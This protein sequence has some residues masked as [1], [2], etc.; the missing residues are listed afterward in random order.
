MNKL[1]DEALLEV[2]EL[3]KH[4]PM[5]KK[6]RQ[7]LPTVVKAVD[8]VS[9]SIKKGKTLGI[10]GE[11]GSGKS[12]VANLILQLEEPTEGAVFFH[13]ENLF[14]LSKG[15]NRDMRKHLQAIFQ[16]PYA[17]LNPRMTAKH[18]VTEPLT[19]HKQLLNKNIN[20]KA[21]ELLKEVGLGKEHLNRYPH[22]F[23]G[24]QRQRLSIARA[25]SLKPD[26]II[27]DEAVSALD[28]S[29]QA[30][31]LNL[32][33][34][35]QKNYGIAYIFIAHGLPAVKHISDR[36]AIMYAGKIV[37]LA[38]R[39]QLF[40]N[41]KHP[42]TKAL[43]DAIPPSD[44]FNRKERLVLK[45]DPPSTIDPPQGCAFHPRCPYAQEKCKRDTPTLEEQ[46]NGNSFACHFPL[47]D[48]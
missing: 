7:K 39:E 35:L 31:I 23:S 40:S 34:T 33:K 11:S 6:W 8:G 19:L 12:T 43:L 26:L 29:I 4:F 32:L 22:E 15:S 24:G 3:K 20:E 36:I 14:T 1:V 28:V 17:S 30:Q 10:V 41:P 38:D 46:A 5:K 47:P 45:G 25:L 42:Y 27:C 37:E 21:L 13:G 48:S 9:F 2:S 44:P 16:D 18:I